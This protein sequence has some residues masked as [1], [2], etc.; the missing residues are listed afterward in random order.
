MKPISALTLLLMVMHGSWAQ[1]GTSSIPKAFS[2]E[3]KADSFDIEQ[4][5]AGGFEK[6]YPEV[7][8]PCTECFSQED[9]AYMKL[10]GGN[11]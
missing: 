3:V 9:C 2:K 1:H 7:E 5:P 6:A 11:P 8:Q 4:L 10:Y